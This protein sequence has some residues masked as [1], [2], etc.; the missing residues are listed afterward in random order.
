MSIPLPGTYRIRSVQYP[1]QMFDL[2][3]GSVNAGTPVIGHI[4]NTNSQNMLV[5][6]D[7]LTRRLRLTIS[8]VDLA[9]GGCKYQKRQDD[10]RHKW[11]ICP[12]CE[13]RK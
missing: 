6:V 10:Q 9:S 4:N 8:T 11:H 3:G 5:S 12:T 7:S 13:F 1:N 2:S